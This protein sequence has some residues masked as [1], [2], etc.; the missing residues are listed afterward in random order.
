M[1]KLTLLVLLMIVGIATYS[2]QTWS[3]TTSAGAVMIGKN[4]TSP[5]EK[6]W[7]ELTCK[8]IISDEYISF[9]YFDGDDP[10]VWKILKYS[11]EDNIVTY[12]LQKPEGG[13]VVLKLLVTS[14]N[15]V[16]MRCIISESTNIWYITE[17]KYVHRIY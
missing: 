17:S 8:I 9:D 7:K 3:F 1:K 16:L 10:I 15:D 11:T 5:T 13:T 4:S 12:L 6:D 2:Q 14:N